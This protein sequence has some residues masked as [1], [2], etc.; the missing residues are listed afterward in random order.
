M[1]FGML[2]H[3]REQAQVVDFCLCKCWILIIKESKKQYLRPFFFFF[4]Q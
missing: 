2:L 4:A 3:P 1:A